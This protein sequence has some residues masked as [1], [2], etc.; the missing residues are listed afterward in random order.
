M[1]TMLWYAHSSIH[2]DAFWSFS[3]IVS[4][5]TSI[6]AVSYHNFP[7]SE[8][9]LP[10]VHRHSSYFTRSRRRSCSWR[11]KRLFSS[12]TLHCCCL[13]RSR[14]FN[15]HRLKHCMKKR[16]VAEIEASPIYGYFYCQTDCTRSGM[17]CRL[18]RV[19]FSLA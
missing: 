12:C 14:F 3:G 15:H 9:L 8:A 16:I 10:P 7:P 1:P 4:Y 13:P 2:W 19:D 17:P 5:P 11:W 18:Y 6:T